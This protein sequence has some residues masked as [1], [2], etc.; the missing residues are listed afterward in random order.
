MQEVCQVGKPKP[1]AWKVYLTQTFTIT[2]PFSPS[3]LVKISSCHHPASD[4]ERQRQAGESQMEQ[5][6]AMEG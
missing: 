6:Q 3:L 4:A 1:L 5:S 2:Q